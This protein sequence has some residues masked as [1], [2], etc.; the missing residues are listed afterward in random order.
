M[1]K[2]FKLSTGEEMIA[3]VIDD[4]TESVT[5][6]SPRTMQLHQTPQ[7]ISAGLVPWFLTN[8]DADAQLMKSHIIASID[9]PADVE[10]SY[11][12]QTSKLDLTSR[13]AV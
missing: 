9:C 7:G 1:I 4:Q 5:V 12:Q 6:S 11:R 13:I 10:Q 8:P 2:V 3:N